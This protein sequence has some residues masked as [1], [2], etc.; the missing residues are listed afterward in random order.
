MINVI[1]IR[2]IGGGQELYEKGKVY[3]LTPNEAHTFIELRFARVYKENQE[4]DLQ[5]PVQDKM[6][7]K[8]KG[9][10]KVNLI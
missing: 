2:T 5:M 1:F 10:K 3:S 9:R 7:K 4:K 8:P 6:I